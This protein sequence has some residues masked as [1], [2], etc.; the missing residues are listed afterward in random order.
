MKDPF[1]HRYYVCKVRLASAISPLISQEGLVSQVQASLQ[2]WRKYQ[3]C[4]YPRN[5]SAA[6]KSLC[7]MIALARQRP[8]MTGDLSRP[9][10]PEFGRRWQSWTYYWKSGQ[11]AQR[12]FG[13]T[14]RVSTLIVNITLWI[15][16]ATMNIPSNPAQNLGIVLIDLM[17]LC[18]NNYLSKDTPL[19]SWLLLHQSAYSLPNRRRAAAKS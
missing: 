7:K 9:S 2:L 19:C 17:M 12:R 13:A 4:G 11:H 1:E 5:T 14:L 15:A 8:T 6:D 3:S 16:L 10:G 18:T